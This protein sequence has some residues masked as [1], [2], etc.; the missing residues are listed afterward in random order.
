MFDFTSVLWYNI[1][2]GETMKVR[3]Y[4]DPKRDPLEFSNRK[5]P[6]SNCNHDG[7][8]AC[9]FCNP[10]FFNPTPE[11]SKLS[12][13]ITIGRK[14]LECK[15]KYYSGK[16]SPLSDYDYDHLES[17]LRAIDPDNPVLEFVG[18]E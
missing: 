2:R 18:K 9:A 17:S 14:L 5:P 15:Q 3:E 4:N 11:Q 6:T 13:S 8:K 1:I 16:K 12:S 10:A 7:S